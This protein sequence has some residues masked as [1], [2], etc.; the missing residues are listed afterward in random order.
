MI[1]TERKRE[2]VKRR[3][4]KNAIQNVRF[5]VT[6]TTLIIFNDLKEGIFKQKERL[7]D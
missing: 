5:T 6:Y 1:F 3:N 7:L 2:E 4:D